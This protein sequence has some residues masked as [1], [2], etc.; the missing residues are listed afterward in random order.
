MIKI[1]EGSFCTKTQYSLILNFRVVEEG[2]GGR[3][4]K[5]MK[6]GEND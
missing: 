3:G 5:L 1:L 4:H 2:V 6:L